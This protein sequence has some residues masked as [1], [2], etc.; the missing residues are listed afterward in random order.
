MRLY[1]SNS[2]RIVGHTWSTRSSSVYRE[3]SSYDMV[4]GR[5]HQGP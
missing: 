3:Q 1:T 5:L 4:I 2:L